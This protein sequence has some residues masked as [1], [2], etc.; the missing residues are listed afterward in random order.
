MDWIK[1]G[2]IFDLNKI[3]PEWLKSHAMTPTPLLLEDRIRV[4]FTGRNLSGKSQISF[5]DTDKENPSII[6]Y[7]HNKPLFDVGGLGSFD[8]CGTICTCAVE[9][10]GK[11]YLYY[12]AYS[13]SFNVPYR[14]SIGVAVSDD[15]GFSFSRM[16]D[17]PILDR[18]IFDPYFVISPW[19]MKFNDKWH[20]WYSSCDRWLVI[21]N[22]PES[23]YH[24]KYAF[25]NDGLSWEREDKSCILPKYPDEANARPSVIYQ[26]AKL[27][28]WFT[29]RGSQDFRDGTDSYK[30]GYAEASLDK[31]YEWNRLDENSGFSLSEDYFDNLM[32]AYPSVISLEDKDVM[33][34]N[35]N[36]FGISGV[37]CAIKM[38]HEK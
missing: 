35:G 3:K 33:F 27:K 10:S 20:L 6:L 25:S 1:L 31:P 15:N 23:V 13:V 8:D 5:F 12:T 21:H 34:Y 18:N 30:I 24:I 22:K 14:N 11:I 2:L 9:D 26:D 4:F 37:C 19:V 38:K 29:Y 32:Q 17:G 36:G 7:V 28:M 16:F